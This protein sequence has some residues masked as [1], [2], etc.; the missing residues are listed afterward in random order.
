MFNSLVVKEEWTIKMVDG[1]GCEVI[2]T[3]MV[4][5]T[6]RDGTVRTLVVVRYVLKTRYNLISMGC[7]TK[8]DVGSKCNTEASS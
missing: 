8:K 6:G 1:S 2:N 4:N 7:S 3:E 5:V